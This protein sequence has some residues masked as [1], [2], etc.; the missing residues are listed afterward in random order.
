VFEEDG[1]A[2]SVLDTYINSFNLAYPA[3]LTASSRPSSE[4]RDATVLQ[5]QPRQSLDVENRRAVNT[6][7][8]LA[9]QGLF[10]LTQRL[11]LQEL[12]SFGVDDAAGRR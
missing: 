10:E 7:E 8:S 3:R 4:N 6:H 1:P 11:R 2:S 9:V 5:L 12:L